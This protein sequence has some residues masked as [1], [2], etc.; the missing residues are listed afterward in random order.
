MYDVVPGVS[1]Y[2]NYA[3]GVET[4]GRAPRDATNSNELMPS[5]VSEQYETGIK[6]QLARSAT[7][8]AAIFQI[9]RPSEFYQ[10]P[11]THY[12]QDGE[13]R[14]RGAEVLLRGKILESLRL[15]GGIQYLDAEILAT[16]DPAAVGSN[17]VGVPEWQGTLSAELDVATIP[18]FSLLGIVTGKSE[19]HRVVPNDRRIAPG[20]MLFDLGARYEFDF[21]GKEA[22]AQV[23]VEN[24]A[25]REYAA[26]S[27]WL[28]GVP[29]TVWLS[30]E[31]KLL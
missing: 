24:V 12:V 22:V 28:F 16:G 31:W 14:H 11:G 8:D 17:P 1:L 29:R 23:R 7:V 4:G 9:T 2:A 18:G 13:Q 27:G 15:M 30:F 25:D 3:T 19:R 6:W 26:G 5:L 21:G 20:Y 10:G